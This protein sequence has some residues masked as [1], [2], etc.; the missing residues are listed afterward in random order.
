MTSK[1]TSNETTSSFDTLRSKDNGKQRVFHKLCS[2]S[3]NSQS[4][5]LVLLGPNLT[6]VFRLIHNTE[7]WTHIRF[8]LSDLMLIYCLLP[9]MLWM[10]GWKAAHNITEVQ[11]QSWLWITQWLT[12][13]HEYSLRSRAKLKYID[14][15]R[16]IDLLQKTYQN[17]HLAADPTTWFERLFKNLK[18]NGYYAVTDSVDSLTNYC[19]AFQIVSFNGAGRRQRRRIRFTTR[20]AYRWNT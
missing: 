10:T 18:N 4:H 17:F 12:S 15:L 8:S 9:L 20:P 11:P 6:S 7:V 5:V 1:F 2:F 14:Q 19:Y 13:F 3:R 16:L